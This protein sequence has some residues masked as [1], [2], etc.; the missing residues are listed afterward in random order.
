VI[1]K[2]VRLPRISRTGRRTSEGTKGGSTD[3]ESLKYM[4]LTQII[5]RNDV[6]AVKFDAKYNHTN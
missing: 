1:I 6:F 4:L 5:V 3:V 2:V